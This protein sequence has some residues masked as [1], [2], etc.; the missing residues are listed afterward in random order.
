MFSLALD[1]SW[2]IMNEEEMYDVNGGMSFG[3]VTK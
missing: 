1:N 2:V 3:V